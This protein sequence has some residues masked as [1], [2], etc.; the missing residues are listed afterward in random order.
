M[1]NY[2]NNESFVLDHAVFNSHMRRFSE[3]VHQDITKRRRLPN[4]QLNQCTYSMQIIYPH[5][6][7]YMP[8]LPFCCRT[9]ED[10]IMLLQLRNSNVHLRFV[11]TE[12]TR[13]T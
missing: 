9:I 12:I 4:I 2:A 13:F 11:A 6:M 10:A 5:A 7:Q 8:P 1:V 3:I